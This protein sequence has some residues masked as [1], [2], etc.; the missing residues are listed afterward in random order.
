MQDRF[1]VA[2]VGAGAAGISA[3]RRLAGAGLSVVALEARPRI[4]GRA[5]TVLA[6]PDLPVDCGA[7]WVHSADENLLTGPIEQ[8]GFTLDRSPPHWMRQAFNRDFPPKEQQAFRAALSAL[9]ARTDAAARTGL[10]RPAS[11][12]LE[13]G[14]RWNPLLDA[15]SSY[16]NGAEFDQVSILDYAA[17]ED[18]GV[19]WRVAEGYGSAIASFADLERVVTDCPVSTIHHDGPE[20]VLDTPKGRVTARA[21]IVTTPT[22]ALADGRLAFS[23]GLPDKAAAAAGLPL[24]LADKVFLGVDDPEALPVEGHLFG[25][26]DRTETGS[27]HLRP[28]GRP[29]IEVFLGGRCARALEGEGPGAMTSFALEELGRLMGADFQRGLHPLSETHWAQDPWALGSYSHALPGHA[30]DRAILAAPVENRIFFA[31]EATSARFYS[32][33]HG[34][35]ESGLRAADEAIAALV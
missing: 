31:G 33:V 2:V 7:G 6:R 1:D 21:V 32:T 8:A 26:S 19:N 4:G 23:P 16:Y 22:A 15:F 13:P 35:W 14:S 29:Y 18:S 27:Y 12:F 24:G 9:E 30:G 25:H 34:A 5:H 20:L 10:D 17:Y 11:D 3:L 28:F